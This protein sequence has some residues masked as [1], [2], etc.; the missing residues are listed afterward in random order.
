MIRH[1]LQRLDNPSELGGLFIEQS[2]E[3]L[4]N[5]SCKNF[6]PVLGAPDDMIGYIIDGA[7]IRLPTCT[8][9]FYLQ[10]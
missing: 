10:R 2:L 8:H 4:G 9:S 5:I 7:F 3:A 1:D 6:P